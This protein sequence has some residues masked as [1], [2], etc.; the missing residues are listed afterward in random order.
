MRGRDFYHEFDR[1]W[2]LPVYFQLRWK[3]IVVNLEETLSEICIEPSAVKGRLSS[4]PDR[5]Y[6]YSFFSS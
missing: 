2:Q 4:F 5:L 1:R 6:L 3:E